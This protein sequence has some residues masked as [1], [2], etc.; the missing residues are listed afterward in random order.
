MKTSSI[1]FS[2]IYNNTNGS[3]KVY[4]NVEDQAILLPTNKLANSFGAT[5]YKG[6]KRFSVAVKLEEGDSLTKNLSKI[7]EHI[8]K[9]VASNKELYKLLGQKKKP[10]VD[11]L[12]M[13]YTPI[14]KSSEKY[15]D[16]FNVKLPCVW[17]K[18]T[19]KTKFFNTDKEELEL[20][21]SDIGEVIT[22]QTLCKYIIHIEAVWF[23]NGKFGVTV[24]A[25]QVLV[26]PADKQLEGFAFVDSD[27][28]EEEEEVLL[29]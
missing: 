16:S 6:N 12:G 18:D 25:K 8:V 29:V 13:V 23:V 1:Q 27:T 26:Y 14:V 11:Q 28:E 9:Q 3:S 17:E 24:T 7:D 5:D 4:L 10:T 20:D 22:Y 2:K 19:F 21:T 15:G